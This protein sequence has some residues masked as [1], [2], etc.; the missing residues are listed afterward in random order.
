MGIIC[1]M[2]E[3]QY[4]GL[5]AHNVAR[6][7]M[8]LLRDA[9]GWDR[10]IRTTDGSLW[11]PFGWWTPPLSDLVKGNE[12]RLV[13]ACVAWAEEQERAGAKRYFSPPPLPGLAGLFS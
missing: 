6:R 10:C 9:R 7:A 5:D 2:S 11:T 1:D 13:A 3:E 12:E 4:V 8:S